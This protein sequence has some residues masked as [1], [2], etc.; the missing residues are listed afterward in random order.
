[1][2]GGLYLKEIGRHHRHVK[3]EAA[4]GGYNENIF[5]DSSLTWRWRFPLLSSQS[6]MVRIPVILTTEI[7]FWKNFKLWIASNFFKLHNFEKFQFWEIL[8]FWIASIFENFHL[9]EIFTFEKIS[10]FGKPFKTGEVSI[11]QNVQFLKIS[12]LEKLNFWKNHIPK[13]FSFGKIRISIFGKM[14]F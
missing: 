8:N 1:M 2:R 10:I 13:N 14:N 9:F 3:K 4:R 11:L 12:N 6:P 7:N 5:L